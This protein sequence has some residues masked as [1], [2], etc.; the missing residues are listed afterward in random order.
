MARRLLVG[1][2]AL[3]L[4]ACATA[5][6]DLDEPRRIVGTQA[7]VRVDA[8]VFAEKIG[9]GSSVRVVWEIQNQRRDPIAVAEL[10]PNVTYDQNER[11]IVVNIGSEVPGNELLPRLIRI[12]SGERKAFEGLAKIGLRLPPP[13]PLSPSPRFLQ[14]KLSFLSSVAPFVS[15]VGIPEVAVRDPR[16]A[17]ELFTAWVESNETVST[18]AIPIEWLGNVS[19]ASLPDVARPARGG[20]GKQ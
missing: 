18:N 14:L 1:I 8:Q 10:L 19:P 16:K 4:A 15:L 5:S 11:T 7:D 12:E 17:D 13:G 3:V 2:C 9:S 20:S 6:V